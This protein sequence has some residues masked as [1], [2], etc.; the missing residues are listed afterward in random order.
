MNCR[1]CRPGIS[2]KWD[3]LT[4]IVLDL[5]KIEHHHYNDIGDNKSHIENLKKIINK[6]DFSDLKFLRIVGGEPFYSPNLHWF[7]IIKN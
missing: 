4:N 2:S 6:T 5:K 3:A 7:R 1:I